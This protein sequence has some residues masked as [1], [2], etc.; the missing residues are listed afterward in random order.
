LKKKYDPLWEIVNEKVSLQGFETTRA[1][2]CPR[3]YVVVDIS[4][5]MQLGERFRCGLCGVLCEVAQGRSVADN[6]TAE[7]VARLTE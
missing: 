1:V 3:C 2:S 7:I 6:G 5:E 4:A